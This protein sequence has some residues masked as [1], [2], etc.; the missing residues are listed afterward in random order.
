MLFELFIYCEI[1]D[2][3]VNKILN[4]IKFLFFNCE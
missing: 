4:L 1:N 2:V 3:Y